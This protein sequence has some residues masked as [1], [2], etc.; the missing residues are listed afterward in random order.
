MI[1]CSKYIDFFPVWVEFFVWNSNELLFLP[2]RKLYMKQLLRNT[3]IYPVST[4]RKA[5]NLKYYK[6]EIILFFRFSGCTFFDN[7]L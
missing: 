4:A 2:M 1:T 6:N 7:S 3:L 5:F